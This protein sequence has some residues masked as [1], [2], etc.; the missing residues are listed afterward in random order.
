MKIGDAAVLFL[1]G[2]SELAHMADFS[3]W[4]GDP[5]SLHEIADLSGVRNRCRVKQGSHPLNVIDK[6]LAGIERDE[7]FEKGYIRGLRRSRIFT[8]KERYRTK[9]D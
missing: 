7:R 6:V 4:V 5:S 9:N 3:L 1:N 2:D 8:L